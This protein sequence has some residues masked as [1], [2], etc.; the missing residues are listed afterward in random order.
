MASWREGSSL[1]WAR[2][3]YRHQPEPADGRE[4]DDF[5]K[6][7]HGDTVTRRVVVL[8]P[9]C[10]MEAL[11]A[12]VTFWTIPSGWELAGVCSLGYGK[13]SS[14]AVP[15]E[16]RAKPLNEEVVFALKW[17]S[18]FGA[19]CWYFV[20]F[21]G[22]WIGTELRDISERS[23]I[24][25][26]WPCCP[27]HKVGPEE[28]EGIHDA[29]YGPY[30]MDFWEQNS[31]AQIH[32]LSFRTSSFGF[33]CWISKQYPATCHHVR[34]CCH[35]QWKNQL[36]LHYSWNQLLASNHHTDIV[37]HP[38]FTTS[39]SECCLEK[40]QHFLLIFEAKLGPVMVRHLV[41]ESSG[42]A[43]LSDTETADEAT[44]LRPAPAPLVFWLM[45]LGP[46]SVIFRKAS[47]FLSPQK[48]SPRN[49]FAKYALVCN[50]WITKLS[51]VDFGVRFFLE[52]FFHKGNTVSQQTGIGLLEFFDSGDSQFW[53]LRPFGRWV[54]CR[55]DVQAK[56]EMW[57][58]FFQIGRSLSSNIARLYLCWKSCA[59][60][61][62]CED[63][64][65]LWC[66]HAGT[67]AGAG[68]RG[69]VSQLRQ[70]AE[71]QGVLCFLAGIS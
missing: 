43:W 32:L 22:Y 34:R 61:P 63:D 58:L 40:K 69:H 62:S 54:V 29:G 20:R 67:C 25:A 1:R 59:H 50:A 51:G 31:V 41:D 42:W 38:Q 6:R 64:A 4:C 66:Q 44:V 3:I 17:K 24:H 11:V 46:S 27:S 47:D 49:T 23:S 33:T 28:F 52:A 13:I 18:S 57:N 5:W 26:L 9:Y 16:L 37:Q 70:R 39:A 68:A 2:G 60:H 36:P 7:W 48:V 30:L 10:L 71:A 14:M 45:F 53:K 56:G 8:Q 21:H 12:P 55:C 15:T 35:S 65:A 19:S